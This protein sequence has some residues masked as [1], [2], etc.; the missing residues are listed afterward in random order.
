MRCV[1]CY[2]IIKSDENNKS[3]KCKNCLEGAGV[4]CKNQNQSQYKN[5][6]SSRSVSTINNNNKYS[7]F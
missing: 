5:Q 6:N 7:V 3:H 4:C 2:T 1:C